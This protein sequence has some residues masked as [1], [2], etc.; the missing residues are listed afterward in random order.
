MLWGRHE[1]KILKRFYYYFFLHNWTVYFIKNHILIIFFVIPA[2]EYQLKTIFC[3]VDNETCWTVRETEDSVLTIWRNVVIA[4][5]SR[6][7]ARSLWTASRNF[8]NS[9]SFLWW[10]QMFVFSLVS[11]CT[12]LSICSRLIVSFFKWKLNIFPLMEDEFAV[13][14]ILLNI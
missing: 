1:I 3:C 12:K 4:I 2:H 5:I 11:K 7:R 13:S 8:S 14:F 9:N 6:N 10:W